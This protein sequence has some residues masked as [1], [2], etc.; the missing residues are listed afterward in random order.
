MKICSSSTPKLLRE[1]ATL[2][3][4]PRVAPA[5]A[6]PNP[7]RA[8][9][10]LP[11]PRRGL[12]G[13]LAGKASAPRDGEALA[14]KIRRTSMPHWLLVSSGTSAR[15]PSA[16]RRQ[17]NRRVQNPS[18]TRVIGAKSTGSFGDLYSFLRKMAANRRRGSSHRGRAS[19]GRATLG[20]CRRRI[21]RSFSTKSRP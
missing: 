10:G 8:P 11:I 5:V 2:P 13:N 18:G 4:L 20:R 9:G 19:W 3:A 12:R 1:F 7:G 17:L 15:R 14:L 21:R 16:R 6:P